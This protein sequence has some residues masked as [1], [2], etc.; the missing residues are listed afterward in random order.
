MGS[1][2]VPVGTPAC[3][4]WARSLRR[5]PAS[6]EYPPPPNVSGQRLEMYGKVKGRPVSMHRTPHWDGVPKAITQLSDRTYYAVPMRMRK[7][8]G[9]SARMTVR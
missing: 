9:N 2:D 6:G 3:H 8:K 1:G 5:L 4:V 7:E